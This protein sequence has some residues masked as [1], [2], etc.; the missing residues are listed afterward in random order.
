MLVSEL[1]AKEIIR[2]LTGGYE[3]DD[4]QTVY[5]L[6]TKNELRNYSTDF[7]YS[8]DPLTVFFISKYIDNSATENYVLKSEYGQSQSIYST[9]AQQSLFETIDNLCFTHMEGDPLHFGIGWV[10]KLKPKYENTQLI[11]GS[12]FPSNASSLWT[13]TGN[14]WTLTTGNAASPTNGSALSQ[15]VSG[16]IPNAKYMIRFKFSGSGQIKFSLGGTETAFI[17]NLN[18]EWQTVEVVAGSSNSLIR[19]IA[20]NSSIDLK[21]VELRKCIY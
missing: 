9:V 15:T 3:V 4:S 7:G 10:F 20:G 18:S 5:K 1:N 8:V 2:N 14:A 16:L 11:N 19:C 21:N 13:N 6:I 12:D 17:S